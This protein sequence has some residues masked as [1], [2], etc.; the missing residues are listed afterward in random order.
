MRI[1]FGVQ[2]LI[3]RKKKAGKEDEIFIRSNIKTAGSNNKTLR[4]KV[5]TAGSDF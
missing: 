5:A 2:K 1:G 4:I 3:W